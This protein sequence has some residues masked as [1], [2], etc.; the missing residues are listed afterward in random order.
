MT[1]YFGGKLEVKNEMAMFDIKDLFPGNQRL[2]LSDY[3]C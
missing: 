2:E 1:I 3:W